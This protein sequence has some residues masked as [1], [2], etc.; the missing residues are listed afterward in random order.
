VA[1]K[2]PKNY[3]HAVQLL[4]DLRDLAARDDSAGFQMQLAAFRNAHAR[5]PSLLARLPKAGL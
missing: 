1:T 4:V 3:D 2:L 5:K